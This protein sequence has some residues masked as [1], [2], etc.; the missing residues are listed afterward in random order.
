MTSAVAVLGPSDFA[1]DAGSESIFHWSFYTQPP[2]RR[3]SKL[4][5]LTSPTKESSPPLLDLFGLAPKYITEDEDEPSSSDSEESDADPDWAK[6]ETINRT[7]QTYEFEKQHYDLADLKVVLKT[8]NKM[9]CFLVASHALCMASKVWKRIIHPNGFRELEY[10]PR[11]PDGASIKVIRLEDDVANT[12]DIIFNIIHLE[13]D[14]IPKKLSF[15]RLRQMAIICDKYECAK[16]LGPWPEMWMQEHLANAT[17]PGFEDWLFIAKVLDPTQMKAKEI[18]KSL[19]METSSKSVCGTYIKRFT[20]T[21]TSEK[22]FEVNLELMPD[23]IKDYVVKERARAVRKITNML[24]QFVRELSRVAFDDQQPGYNVAIPLSYCPTCSDIAVGSLIRSLKR[25]LLWPLLHG[26]GRAEWHG[27]LGALI[28]QVECLH[29]TTLIHKTSS[30]PVVPAR[31]SSSTATGGR[32]SFSASHNRMSSA[33]TIGSSTF[34]GPASNCKPLPEEKFKITREARSTRPNK[35]LDYGYATNIDGLKYEFP[36]YHKDSYHPAYVPCT[37]AFG[38]GTL[39]TRCRKVVEKL[40]AAG[41]QESI[42][43]SE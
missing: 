38:L 16:A 1:F 4:S 41:Y 35:T 39:I 32:A 10:E 21:P 17:T 36:A 8:N 29:M 42:D 30:H 27:S 6:S 26:D 34:I 28:A 9:Y 7:N 2:S 22:E 31:V 12:L 11:G 15:R 14:S 19:V 13:T 33:S 24:R 23:S 20:S 3:T 5:K 37:L 40:S 18:T 43:I 25:L